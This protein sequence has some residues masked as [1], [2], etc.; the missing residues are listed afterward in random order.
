M[1]DDELEHVSIHRALTRHN[2]FLGGDREVVM[3]SGLIAATLIFYALDYRAAIAGVV[4]WFFS[5]A[6]CRM[7]AKHDPILRMVYMR[8]R[9]Y[10]PYYPPLSTPW[11]S[12]TSTQER[13]YRV[14]W[15]K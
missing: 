6:L 10:K 8:H 15:K 13:R 7:M 11:R 3:F 1:N 14:P 4:F 2:L 5:L 9:M 12:N